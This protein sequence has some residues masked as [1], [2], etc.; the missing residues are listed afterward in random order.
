VKHA[1]RRLRRSP[2]FTLT[3]LVTLGAAIGANAL[4]FSVVSAVVLKPLPFVNPDELVGVWHVAP[5]LMSGDLNQSPST[6]FTYREGGV[7][8]DIG[9][10]DNSA[11]SITGRGDPERVDTLNVTDGTLTLLGVRPALGRTFTKEDDSPG[12]AETVI[13]S[14]DYWM[15]AFGGNPAA[16]GQSL[17]VDG[18]PR[19][20]IGVLPDGFRFLRYNPALVLPF[21]FNRAELFVGNFS[22]QG[23]ARLKPGS[24]MTQASADMARLI[25][26][27]PDH[28]RMPPGFTRQMFDEVKLGPNLHA[29]SQD[30][31]GDVGRTLWILLGTVGIVLLVACANIANLFLV[32]AEGRQ[33]ELAVRASLGATATQV[34]GGLLS[35]ALVLSLAAG[36]VGLALAYGG[37]R[38]LVLLNPARLPRL[39]EIAIDPM[40]VAFVLAISVV[41]G[42]LFGLLPVLKYATPR[43]A[44]T[45]KEGSRG[46]SDG[47]E[48]H[49]ARN[50]LVIAQVAL[51]LVLLVASGLMVRTFVAMRNVSP[52][53]TNPADVLTVRIVIPE[54][55]IKD[56]V[57]AALAHERIRETIGAIPGVTAVAM[58]S[59]ITM[60]GLD[61]NDPI[62]VEDRP[63]PEGQIPPLRR[64]KWLSPDYFKTMG[65]RI[66]AGRDFTWDDVHGRRPVAIVSENLAREFWGTPAAAL[67]KRVR[68]SPKNDWREVV[69]VA[70]DE[71]D[72]GVTKAAPTIMF[73]PMAMNNFWDNPVFVQRYLS[74]AIRTP[75]VH[76]TGFLREVQQ[77]VWSINPNLP[78]ARISTLERIY[79]Q[80]MAQTS[81][82]LVVL[83]IAAA[84]AMLLGLVGIYGVIAYVVA[85]RRRE[86]G[87]RMAIGASSGDVQRLFLQRGL[88]LTGVGL[89]LGVVASA[90]VMRLMAVLLF[91]VTPFD[92]VTY[93][94]GVS[95]LGAVALLATWLPARQATRVDPALA[96]RSE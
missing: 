33:Q 9:M 31:V 21:R 67:G 18:S 90:A 60:D 47:R 3:A 51:S 12:S 61:S 78:L 57:E 55:V 1:L 70:G 26:G 20:I 68:N 86:V 42:L 84:V 92:P 88:I 50:G 11:A 58:T 53:F 22:Y 76:N 41:A 65:N 30:L 56:D 72:D 96:L 23:V 32:R 89:A 59:S 87:I 81:F 36:A 25:P 64:Y 49:R 28:F 79:D 37:I 17:N 24:S 80:S 4:I 19:R 83:G 34:A 7:F 43:L 54:G 38:L 74:Y 94:A 69:G 71:R 93:V 52:G 82:A 44:A 15:R 77:A 35:E 29:L 13:L 62:W 66:V 85:Q 14:H 95:G 5:G 6:Y 8:Q 63:A 40:V 27:I 39:D 75:R 45:L 46:S 16:L 73:W 2:A 91:G 48:R 10:W